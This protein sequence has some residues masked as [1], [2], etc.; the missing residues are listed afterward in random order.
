MRETAPV[1][2]LLIVASED[3]FFI[4]HFMPAALAAQNAGYEVHVSVRVFD[5]KK[6]DQIRNSGFVLHPSSHERGDFGP[7]KVLHHVFSFAGLVRSVKPD[8]VHLVSLRLIFLGALGAILAGFLLKKPVRRVHAVT[9]LGFVGSGTGMKHRLARLVFGF[10]LRTCLNGRHVRTVFENT[11]DPAV[12]GMALDDPKILILGGAG[13]DPERM[14]PSAMP[15]APPLKLALVA[16]LVWSKGVDVAVAAV[17][18][19]RSRGTAV[20][21]SLY[22]MPDPENPCSFSAE[23]LQAWSREGSGII[24]HGHSSDISAVW[25]DHHVACVPSRGGEGLPR[26]LLEA[27]AAGRAILTTRTPGCQDFVRDGAEGLLCPPG[28]VEALAQAIAT[29]AGD[30]DQV[31]A[32]GAA[33]R[34]RI[35]EGFTTQAVA[36][37][38]VQLYNDMMQAGT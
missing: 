22:G 37:A 35:F 30:M 14:V 4:S 7:F 13:V 31:H 9:G 19:A 21:L 27:A 29:M 20:T 15:E 17:Q 38:F 33:A 16:R 11:S 18:L 3:W 10:L 34:A 25:R 1:P 32:M 28:D 24:W 36:T 6:A 23:T 2:R 26:T 12:L 8:I 5:P